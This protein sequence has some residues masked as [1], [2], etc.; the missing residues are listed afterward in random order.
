N[1]FTGNQ[2][3]SQLKDIDRVILSPGVPRKIP[4]IQSAIEQKIPVMSEIELAYLLCNPK[5]VI[6]ITGTDGKTTTT[7]LCNELIKEEFHVL[8]GGNIGIPFIS[9]V[10]DV[11]DDTIILLE[12]SSYQ[13]EDIPYFNCN[14]A[15]LLNISEDHLDRYESFNHY[16]DAKKNIFK[17]QS[18]TD[19]AILNLDDNHYNTV[20]QGIKSQ[21]MSFSKSNTNANAYVINNKIIFNDNEI[22]SLN[23]IK[24]KGVHNLENI[25]ASV[26]IAKLVG[27][28]NKSIQKV[29][30]EFRGL[31]HRNEFIASV[32]GIDFI[33]DSKATTINSVIK[34][35]L[36]QDKP[37]ILLM[38]GQDKGLDFSLLKNH[39][40]Q[41]VKKLILFGEAKEK[42]DREIQFSPKKTIENLE[43]A[44]EEALGS[45]VS[46]DIILLSPGCTSF[47]Q[48]SNYE[49]RGN[50]FRE[51]VFKLKNKDN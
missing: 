22:I 8:M 5:L 17:N 4:I 28:S 36:S 23:N 10:D 49:E 21:I 31:P 38:G 44:F 25:L 43:S 29:I 6:G 1:F 24:L 50:H 51:L 2:D 19:Y 48:Y 37:I 3:I 18:S 40:E 33:N 41:R 26:I 32:C 30:N 42:I 35:L 45:A 7:S 16:I 14:I 12:L 46:G 20:S 13:L 9:F 34:S 47:D 11:K 39:I 27:V 15:A